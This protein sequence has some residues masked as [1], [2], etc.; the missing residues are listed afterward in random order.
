M[1]KESEKIVKVEY[2]SMA[3]KQLKDSE[4]KPY[5]TSFMKAIED[6]S[7][8]N[9]AITGK[10]GA[11]KS[12]I[13]R[14]IVSS[15]ETR[16]INWCQKEKKKVLWLSL[17]CFSNNDEV[18]NDDPLWKSIEKSLVQQML[19]IPANKDLPKS[20]YYKIEPASKTQNI[21]N[22]IV[23]VIWVISFILLMGFGGFNKKAFDILNVNGNVKHWILMTEMFLFFVS[24]ILILWK[25]FRYANDKFEI[26]KLSIGKSEF[27]INKSRS[28]FN[29]YFDEILYFFLQKQ[30]SIVIFE[31]IDR[32]D[33]INVFEHLRELNNLLNNNEKLQKI[34]KKSGNLYPIKFVYAVRDDIFSSISNDENGNESK[35]TSNIAELN[36][37]FFEWIIPVISFMSVSNSAQYL[38]DRFHDSNNKQFKSFL[39]EI[40]IYCEDVRTWV[41]TIN[42]FKLYQALL[43]TMED[44]NPQQLFSIL[45]LK[46][47]Y[48][49]EFG[50][51]VKRRG[52]LHQVLYTDIYYGK[53]I[54]NLKKDLEVATDEYSQIKNMDEQ[55]VV[56]YFKNNLFNEG[57]S[58]KC[59]IKNINGSSLALNDITF[60]ELQNLY[61]ESIVDKKDITLSS[62]TSYGEQISF[63]D[64]FKKSPQLDPALVFS[65]N[66]S[67]HYTFDENLKNSVTKIGQIK[68]SISNIERKSII[69]LIKC[70]SD[71]IIDEILEYDENCKNY[72]RFALS[73]GYIDETANLYLV[74][75]N[76]SQISEKDLVLI[77]KIRSGAP[78]EFSEKVDNIDKFISN[79]NNNDLNK[80]GI[81]LAKIIQ[82]GMDSKL[83]NQK[84]TAYKKAI[85]FVCD[86]NNDDYDNNIE[87]L[88]SIIFP[89]VSTEDMSISEFEGRKKLLNDFS[90]QQEFKWRINDKKIKISLY[91]NLLRYLDFKDLQKVFDNTPDFI[92]YINDDELN[93]GNIYKEDI[94]KLEKILQ[95]NEI[96]IR[97]I[98][99]HDFGEDIRSDFI[100]YLVGKNKL[101]I[102]ERTIPKIIKSYISNEYEGVSYDLIINIADEN[103]Q[104]FVDSNINA[105]VNTELELSNNSQLAESKKS[106][107]LLLN[108][109]DLKDDLKEKLIEKYKNEDLDFEK[110]PKQFATLIFNKNKY[111]F[112]WTNLEFIEN[113]D[114][115]NEKELIK[116]VSSSKDFE[117]METLPSDIQLIRK[118][119][120]I[121]SIK[122][123]NENEKIIKLVNDYDGYNQD[124][125]TLNKMIKLN[126]VRLSD[127]LIESPALTSTENGMINLS[128][129]KIV[130][131]GTELGDME[132]KL[133][134]EL[135]LVECMKILEINDISDK[136]EQ[137]VLNIVANEYLDDLGNKLEN[138]IKDDQRILVATKFLENYEQFGLF[139]IKMLKLLTAGT[140]R[141]ETDREEYELVIKLMKLT[142]KTKCLELYKIV[143]V[144][145]I[146]IDRSSLIN[147]FDGYE[148]LLKELFDMKITGIF[149]DRGNKLIVYKRKQRYLE[150]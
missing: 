148:D 136:L 13:L 109:D 27:E 96:L 42:E 130:G 140:D 132:Q 128:I 104:K 74:T 40:S 142:E 125:D 67:K 106:M 144:P 4:I 87:Y 83:S 112:S 43:G 120:N 45:F 118:A 72:L 84:N 70:D 134:N 143:P 150:K 115:F 147:K 91:D 89:S 22:C 47:E 88:L 39:R 53:L 105:F 5:K 123:T 116:F 12:T 33:D 57:Y 108:N 107:I 113:E 111:S 92:T 121:C 54:D 79:L 35:N 66:S 69:E 103:L 94:D 49:L 124:K 71:N 77:R 51:F 117:K 149:H 23:G 7:V 31:D 46:N 99:Y 82:S 2:E 138:D 102:N 97:D 78:T 100:D 11:G 8:K 21:I 28:E 48:P 141:E 56:S 86:R 126:L 34:Y 61:N 16:E 60:D 145:N 14:S 20:R 50:E 101:Q 26:S 65:T 137:N 29:K 68:N 73:E 114:S 17:A 93:I 3:P 36:T 59:Y 38:L 62:P 80:P 10:Y 44:Y 18:K 30:Y 58:G 122:I 76:S 119:V 98:I 19:Y 127:E 139:Y 24:I 63:D 146:N 1:N 64:F 37:K 131:E 55:G 9:I 85:E 129:N 135:D 133:L 25:L 6:P 32:F 95:K 81:K 75:I 41:S 15:I 110:V 90:K 52:S